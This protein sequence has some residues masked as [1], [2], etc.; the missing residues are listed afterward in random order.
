M[1]RTAYISPSAQ[2]TK[3][4]IVQAAQKAFCDR[5]YV[6][7]SVREIARLADVSPSLIIHYFTSKEALF[8]EAFGKSLDMTALLSPARENFGGNA[9]SLLSETHTD[10]VIASAMIAQSVADPNARAIVVRK[11]EDAALLPTAEWLDSPNAYARAQLVM[12]LTLGFTVLRLLVPLGGSSSN[13]DEQYVR[14]WLERALQ[15]LAN[16]SK[17]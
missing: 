14:D 5:G 8:E 9:V 6:G 3:D 17:L 2:E 7:A 16:G 1:L 10:T 11:M 13:A 15:H 12:M 4:R